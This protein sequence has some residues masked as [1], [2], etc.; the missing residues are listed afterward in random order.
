MTS[1]KTD[2]ARRRL[3]RSLNGLRPEGGRRA[4]RCINAI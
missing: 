4:I 1:L 3:T 2:R